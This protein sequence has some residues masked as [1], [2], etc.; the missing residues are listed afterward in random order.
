MRQILGVMLGLMPLAAAAQGAPNPCVDP[1]GYARHLVASN[2]GA[3]AAVLADALLLAQQA[4]G[5]RA[6]APIASSPLPATTRCAWERLGFS[7][8]WVCRPSF[9]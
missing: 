3:D 8:E 5:C 1:A 6:P 7:R 4:Y 9:N 2:P